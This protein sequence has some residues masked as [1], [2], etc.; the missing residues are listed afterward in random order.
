MIKMWQIVKGMREGKY[1]NGDMFQNADMGD[2]II[3]DDVLCYND[4]MESVDIVLGDDSDWEE[5]K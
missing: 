5:I 2:M 4:C 1:K 3:H